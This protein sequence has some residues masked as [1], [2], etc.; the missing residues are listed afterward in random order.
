MNSFLSCP[1]E[2]KSNAN[3]TFAK[4]KQNSLL[5][6]V[7]VSYARFVCA[8]GLHVWRVCVPGGACYGSCAAELSHRSE[9]E[10]ARARTSL[11]AQNGSDR[12]QP[13][14]RQSNNHCEQTWRPL[15]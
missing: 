14:D 15:K 11:T 2:I 10:M 12:G 9:S 3:L 13:R 8:C 7:F 6:F 5:I 1:F 4:T